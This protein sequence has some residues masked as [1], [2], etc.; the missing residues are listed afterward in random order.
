MATV[1]GE[2]EVFPP[3]LVVELL[4][5]GFIELEQ[6]RRPVS[7][8]M[9]VSLGMLVDAFFISGSPELVSVID[10]PFIIRVNKRAILVLK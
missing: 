6:P 9:N 3:V 2:D 10:F 1:F 4:P 7:M 5:Y 8:T